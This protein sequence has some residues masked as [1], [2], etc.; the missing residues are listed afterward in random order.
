MIPLPL[1]Y[2]Y[3][4][5]V[6]VNHLRKELT[7]FV[8]AVSQSQAEVHGALMKDRRGLHSIIDLNTMNIEYLPSDQISPIHQPHSF[9][10]IP[11]SF[12]QASFRKVN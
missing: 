6:W 1:D 3:W 5:I 10:T 8:P 11:L 2:T 12:H 9:S 7:L 4:G